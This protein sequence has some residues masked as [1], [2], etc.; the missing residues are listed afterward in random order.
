MC[1]LAWVTV[2]SFYGQQRRERDGA[3]ACSL[4]GTVG[5]GGIFTE[6][7]LRGMTVR[8][9]TRLYIQ[10][11]ESLQQGHITQR[12]LA[13]HNNQKTL[14]SS[15]DLAEENRHK[16]KTFLCA[17]ATSMQILMHGEGHWVA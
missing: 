10:R 8:L 13:G 7:I 3:V 11:I 2:L 1:E 9:L 15:L 6:D 16:S 12:T 5:E 4:P 17:E 14:Q